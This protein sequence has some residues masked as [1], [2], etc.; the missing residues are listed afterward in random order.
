MLNEKAF[1]VTDCDLKHEI[2]ICDFKMKKTARGTAG[3]GSTGERS[4]KGKRENNEVRK[5]RSWERG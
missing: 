1:K 4:D 2:T 5:L 3:T